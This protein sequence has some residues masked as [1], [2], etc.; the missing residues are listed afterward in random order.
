MIYFHKLRNKH[1]PSFTHSSVGYT[2]KQ[3]RRR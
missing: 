1:D 2:R 3:I